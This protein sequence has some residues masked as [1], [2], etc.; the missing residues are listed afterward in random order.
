MTYLPQ[1]RPLSPLISVLN[2]WYHTVLPHRRQ[3][4]YADEKYSVLR[5]RRLSGEQ[6][7][8]IEPRTNFLRISAKV[9][10]LFLFLLSPFTIHSIKVKYFIGGI[11]S[12]AGMYRKN[13]SAG[14]NE[15]YYVIVWQP[16][17][18]FFNTSQ[19]YF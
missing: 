6:Q 1:L 2:G 9:T 14:S 18:I 12:Q 19:P 10:Y 16:P 17:H 13:N 11:R 4:W 8:K 15:M 5:T 3:N 7:C